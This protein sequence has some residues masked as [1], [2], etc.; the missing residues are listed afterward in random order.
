[1]VTLFVV[2]FNIYEFVVSAVL[3]VELK[4]S[5]NTLGF[6]VPCAPCTATSITHPVGAAIANL[7][8]LEPP[9]VPKIVKSNSHFSLEAILNPNGNDPPVPSVQTFVAPTT[10]TT[11]YSC[12]K[13]T[14]PRSV[15]EGKP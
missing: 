10:L 1:M 9:A 11:L 5:Y 12:G 14:P 15:A 6:A 2:E 8:P 7:I 3:P 4:F 13:K